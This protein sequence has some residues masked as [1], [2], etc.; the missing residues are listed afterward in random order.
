MTDEG[1]KILLMIKL[2]IQYLRQNRVGLL[3]KTKNILKK[4]EVDLEE[5]TE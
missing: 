3:N 1:Y 5:F 4:W 2:K